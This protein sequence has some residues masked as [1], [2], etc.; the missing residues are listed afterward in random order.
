MHI[1][2]C[3]WILTGK[4]SHPHKHTGVHA[5]LDSGDLIVPIIH[6]GKLI[7]SFK[8]VCCS[9]VLAQQLVPEYICIIMCCWRLQSANE[10]RTFVTEQ[11]HDDEERVVGA[12]VG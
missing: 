11:L 6:N 8:D 2:T 5:L 4:A 7:K 10:S 1:N 3:T 9:I 12:A